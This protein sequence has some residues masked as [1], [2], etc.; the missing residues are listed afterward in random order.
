METDCAPAGTARTLTTPS[1][2]VDRDTLIAFW[3]LHGADL[4]TIAAR[5]AAGA[6][7]CGGPGGSSAGLVAD[8]LP[9]IRGLPGA[10]AHDERLRPPPPD[11]L[12]RTIARLLADASKACDRERVRPAG[13]E[14]YRRVASRLGLDTAAMRF[15]GGGGT[16]DQPLR[17]ARAIATMTRLA[18][19]VLG[20]RERILFLARSIPGQRPRRTIASLA[21]E[22]GIG[23]NRAA[24]IERSARRK[25]TAALASEGAGDAIWDL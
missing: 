7:P 3:V 23:E 20:E 4:A 21:G 14:L 6:S 22:L 18:N 2:D 19:E 15:S 25:I 13:G 8:I 1:I 11:R 17:A 9:A 16:A 10:A 5:M 12:A 24:E